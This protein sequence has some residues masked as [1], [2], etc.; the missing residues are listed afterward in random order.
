MKV[1]FELIVL[2][3]FWSIGLETYPK[4]ANKA[5]TILPFS[6]DYLYET[7]F[8]SLIYLKN[9]YRNRLETVENDSRI[10][11]SNRQPRYEKLVDM[12]RQEKSSK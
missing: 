2:D 9:K 12:K 7:G 3:N 11:L 1:E 5:L 6:T 8:S 4:L 10:A